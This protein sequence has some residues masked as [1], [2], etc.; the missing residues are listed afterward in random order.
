MRTQTSGDPVYAMGRSQAEAQ[1]LERQGAFFARAT[2]LL[3]EEAGIGPGMRVLDV[4]SGAGDVALLVAR[5]V[6]P[7]GSVVGVDVNPEIVETAR[8]RAREA[9]L[10]HVSFVAGDIREVEI[11]DEFDA[12]VGRL[13]LCYQADPAATLRAALRSVRDGG[14]AAFYEANLGSLLVSQPE[15]PLHTLLG[16]CVNETFARAGVETFMGTK[17]HRVF[18]DAGLDAPRLLHDALMGGSREFVE[19]YTGYAVHTLRNLLPLTVKYGVATEEE[20]VGIETFESRY[21]DDVLGR[22]SVIRGVDFVGAWSRK[23]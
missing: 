20:E 1:R 8:V 19:A 22:G 17:L 7:T 2:R 16:R 14:V 9:A 23:P 11:E 12:A 3:F 5:L 6:G 4:G 10:A 13:V 15:S 18:L 21:R